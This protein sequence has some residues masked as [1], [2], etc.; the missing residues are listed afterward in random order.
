MFQFGQRRRR[1]LAGQHLAQPVTKPGVHRH[2]ASVAAGGVPG[3]VNTSD[4]GEPVQRDRHVAAPR[5]LH[6]C[7]RK[8]RVDSEHRVVEE[9][10]GLGYVHGIEAA[11]SAEGQAPIRCEAPVKQEI[12]G[13][14]HHPP[15]GADAVGQFFGE[16][17]GG[18]DV[19]AHG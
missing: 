3:S 1:G 11:T 15:G 19:A 9:V 13:V 10:T 17:L 12:L 18:D 16:H 7:A 8:L 5:V 4:V 6:R 14:H 2:A